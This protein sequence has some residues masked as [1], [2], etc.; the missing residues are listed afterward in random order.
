MTISTDQA[1]Y[2]V[3]KEFDVIVLRQALREVARSLDLSLVQQARITA[4]ISDVARNLLTQ[5]WSM[6]F[7]I[8]VH[9]VGVR[10]ALDVVCQ[11]PAHQPHPSYI[12]FESLI[13][14]ESARQLLDE[15]SFSHAAGC[16]LLTL[17]IWI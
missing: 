4:A 11:K 1:E 16:P 7:A 3:N 15:A 10:R 2:T 9:P 12:E 14:I 17:R 6:I 13:S 5:H 8:R